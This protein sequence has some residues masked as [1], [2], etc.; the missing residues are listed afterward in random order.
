MP[1]LLKKYWPSIAHIAGVLIVFLQPSV[2]GFAAS[3]KAQSAT[4]LLLW[5]V[6]LHWF[7]S[8]KNAETVKVFKESEG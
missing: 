7:T 3:H 5:G 2:D 1:S 4:I 6:L 8:P